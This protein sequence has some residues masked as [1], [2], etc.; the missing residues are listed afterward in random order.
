MIIL[1]N[2]E[3]QQKELNFLSYSLQIL[4][5]TIGKKC[6]FQVNRAQ[7]ISKKKKG[8]SDILRRVCFHSLNLTKGATLTFQ[9]VL[10]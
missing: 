2:T 3:E 10:S 8:D 9:Q 4:G 6:N 5:D 1:G 7:L